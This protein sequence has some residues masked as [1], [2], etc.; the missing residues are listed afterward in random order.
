M[1]CRNARKCR[2]A[3]APFRK[4]WPRARNRPCAAAPRGEHHSSPASRARPRRE[5]H[6]EYAAAR[7]RT[8]AKA[9]SPDVV[10]PRQWAPGSEKSQ[11]GEDGLC[12]AL[13]ARYRQKG[14]R[15]A[16]SQCRQQPGD[17]QHEVVPARK[18]EK[19]IKRRNGPTSFGH[20]QWQYPGRPAEAHWWAFDHPP[21]V[22]SDVDGPPLLIS[23]VEIN[24]SAMFRD[25]DVDLT[26]LAIE[27]RSCFQEVE[28]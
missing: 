23:E 22:R 4:P 16:C 27:L 18:I 2:P 24:A 13:L 17:D 9:R 10:A 14:I 21:S 26:F 25:A 11:L 6:R 7:S 3:T 20:G 8:R 5:G 19:R 1:P 15:T 12:G 28:R